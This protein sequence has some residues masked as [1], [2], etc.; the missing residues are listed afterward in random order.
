ML[1]KKIKVKQSNNPSRLLIFISTLS[2]L[3]GFS[4]FALLYGPIVFLELK[5]QTTV[6]QNSF[7]QI[8]LVKKILQQ[9]K[10]NTTPIDTTFGIVIS[11]IG[12]NAHVIP[13]VDPYIEAEYQKALTK[14][15]AHARGSVFPGRVGNVFIFSHSSVN[16]YEAIRYNA[17]FYLLT[18]LH[19]GS[20]IDIYFQQNLYQYQVFETK[21]VNPKEISYLTEKTNEK[22][23]TLMTCW[24]PGTTQERFIVRAKLIE[25]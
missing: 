24:P 15:V 4:I 5:Y 1:P 17:I 12:A 18:K 19:S 3:F 16:F 21:Y 10:I 11:D 22:L 9:G 7:T 25:H 20:I 23:L 13:S 2:I 8:P 14:G 6:S